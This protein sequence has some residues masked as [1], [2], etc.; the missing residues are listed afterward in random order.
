MLTHDLKNYLP[1]KYK[2]VDKL[3]SLLIRSGNKERTNTFFFTF[4]ASIK[5]M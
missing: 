4:I 5:N 2:K 3:K 1:E